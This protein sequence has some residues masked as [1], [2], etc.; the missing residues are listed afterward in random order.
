MNLVG[1]KTLFSTPD[2]IQRNV[3]PT[4]ALEPRQ[5]LRF[6]SK[7]YCVLN[8]FPSTSLASCLR[9][10]LP[11]LFLSSRFSPSRLGSYLPLVQPDLTPPIPLI[12]GPESGLPRALYVLGSPH[13]SHCCILSGPPACFSAFCKSL[14]AGG[15]SYLS[16]CPRLLAR[17]SVCK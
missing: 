10:H 6:Y 13:R 11:T 7:P 12:P 2:L 5:G 3:P 4:W 8:I 17:C 15:M 1:K 16:L 9:H 14:E